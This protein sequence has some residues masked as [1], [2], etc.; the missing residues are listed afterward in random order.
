MDT[1]FLGLRVL[2]SLGAVLG[3]LWF[4]QRRFSR[5]IGSAGT[6]QPVRVVSR[7]PLTP[8]TSLVMVETDGKRLL[9]GVAEGSVNL[10]HAT[11]IPA[12]SSPDA[13]SDAAFA[14]SLKAA[15]AGRPYPSGA[16]DSSSGLPP[17]RSGRGAHALGPMAPV[18]AK[19]ALAGSILAPETWRQAG[20]ALR[21][22]RKG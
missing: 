20:T 8:K 21:R 10:L 2:V 18:P 19:S 22:G 13:A 3:L 17:R 7:Q 12:E 11:E 14:A 4:L 5:T 16:V 6:N 15:E 1:L 9:L